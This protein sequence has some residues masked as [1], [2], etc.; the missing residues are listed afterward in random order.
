MN[1][2]G[3]LVGVALVSSAQSPVRESPPDSLLFG[4]ECDAKT[5]MKL[6][7]SLDEKAI[8][9][10]SKSIK[11]KL[12]SVEPW[13]IQKPDWT[14][15]ITSESPKIKGSQIKVDFTNTSPYEVTVIQAL[16]SVNDQDGD[17]RQYFRQMLYPARGSQFHSG[18]T[19]RLIFNSERKHTMK[20]ITY[21]VEAVGVVK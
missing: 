12:V 10:I 20:T 11:V 8:K 18:C 16:I 6:G 1:I 3:I 2:L 7:R 9:E 19:G 15:Q 5:S 14:G 13:T 17:P 21:R 4:K